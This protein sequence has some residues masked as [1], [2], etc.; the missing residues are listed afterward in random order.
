LPLAGSII[1]GG[2]AMPFSRR[3]RASTLVSLLLPSITCANTVT[4]GVVTQARRANLGNAPVSTGS[5]LYDGD[6]VSTEADGV[7][8]LR[9]GPS[10]VFLGNQSGAMLHGPTGAAHGAQVNLSAGTVVFSTERAVNVEIYADE[11]QIVP[12]TQTHTVGQVTLAGP[13][14]LYVYARRG[15]LKISYREESATISQGESYR[16]LLD[17]PDQNSSAKSAGSQSGS[18]GKHRRKPKAFLLLPF[19]AGPAATG[20]ATVAATAAGVAVATGVAAATVTVPLVMSN[21]YESPDKP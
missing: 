11:A 4:L 5:S 6:R 10:M 14:S 20:A 13:K 3:F 12:A 9:I 19:G 7:L 8:T 17:P 15:S 16:M 21:D 1:P 2:F 18:D